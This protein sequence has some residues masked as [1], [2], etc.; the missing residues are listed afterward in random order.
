MALSI[1]VLGS[2][3]SPRST[4]GATELKRKEATVTSTEEFLFSPAAQLFQAGDYARALEALDR[5]IERYPGDPLLLRYRAIS[6]DRLGRSEEAIEVFKEILEKNQD[7]LPTLYFLGQ[8]Y[9]RL[10]RKQAARSMWQRVVEKGGTTLYAEWSRE[11]LR[12]IPIA[13]EPPRPKPSRWNILT[14]ASYEFDSN[15]LLKPDDKSLASPEDPNASRY[16]VG[17]QLDYRAFSGK[18][19]V[20]DGSYE[21]RQTLHDDS[22]DEFN[23]TFQDFGVNARKQT[24]FRGRSVIGGLEYNILP[25][26]L[27]GD[28]FS[29]IHQWILSADTR[30]TPRTRTVVFDRA[31]LSN[32]GPDGSSP[33]QT[34]RDGFYQDFGI[35]HS[36]YPWNTSLSFFLHEE[37]NSAFTRGDNFDRV[38]N[39]TRVGSHL[40]WKRAAFDVSGG[41]AFGGYPHFSS[42][43]TLDTDRRRDFVW[44]LYT[45]ITYFLTQRWSIRAFYRYVNGQNPS[46]F[47]EYNRHIGGIQ[48]EFSQSF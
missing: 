36:W 40:P 1:L 6:L 30:W 7:H 23:F 25:G 15:V 3:S 39:T 20:V 31:S 4:E 18:T 46:G 12:R 34:S 48:V 8:A 19:F 22:L 10:G 27:N 26:F 47:F 45:S 35:T 13:L 17:T 11:A 33:R 9:F 24:W 42:L 5:L 37:F 29:L 14:R 43:S 28:L 2:A 41:L 44:D 38:G 21:F 32:F 16:T